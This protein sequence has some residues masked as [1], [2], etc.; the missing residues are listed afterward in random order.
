MH[1]KPF[2]LLDV[3]GRGFSDPSVEFFGLVPLDVDL[4]CVPRMLELR[5]PLKAGPLH[6]MLAGSADMMYCKYS[7]IVG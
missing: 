2:S 7:N 3:G 4:N 5:S 6:D 1:F